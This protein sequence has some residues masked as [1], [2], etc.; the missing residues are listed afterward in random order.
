ALRHGLIL[1]AH[2]QDLLLGL[3]ADGMP[4]G[5]WYYRD[6]EGLQVDWR[7]RRAC[8]HPPPDDLPH[9]WVWRE[10]YDTL[11][12]R[13]CDFVWYKWRTSLQHYLH[14]VLNEIE[15]SLRR[16]HERGLIDG[17]DIQP[18]ELTLRFSRHLFDA[19]AGHF[20]VAAGPRYNING[21]LNRFLAS[22]FEL[23]KTWLRL[24]SG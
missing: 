6:F 17:P 20:D 13:Y 5:H 24:R 11:G 9:A 8:G 3:S 21:A 15:I 10:T 7:L 18:G 19:V 23:R 2:A 14:H 16:W 22:V 12:H 1:E 4:T